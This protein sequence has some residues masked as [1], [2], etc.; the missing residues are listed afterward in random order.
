MCL[1]DAFIFVSLSNVF[2]HWMTLKTGFICVSHTLQKQISTYKHLRIST[3]TL[4]CHVLISPYIIV[5]NISAAVHVAIFV[6]TRRNFEA[7]SQTGKQTIWKKD[8]SLRS[9]QCLNKRLDLHSIHLHG[10]TLPHKWSHTV[11]AVS[12][13]EALVTPFDKMAEVSNC[14]LNLLT[15]LI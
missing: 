15:D 13:T 4:F 2:I 5:V 3:L 14:G 10:F 7:C 9:K 1:S 11:F 12:I 8:A 6:S